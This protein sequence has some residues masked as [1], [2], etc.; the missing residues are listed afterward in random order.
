[1]ASLPK[2]RHLRS[3]NLKGTPVSNATLEILARMRWLRELD[4][5]DTGVEKDSLRVLQAALPACI[6]VPKPPLE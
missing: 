2:L 5:R 6:I 1:M 4:L 3:L